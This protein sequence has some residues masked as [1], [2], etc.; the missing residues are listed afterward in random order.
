MKKFDEI[1]ARAELDKYERSNLDRLREQRQLCGEVFAGVLYHGFKISEAEERFIHACNRSMR[2][3]D[4][5]LLSVLQKINA[6][7]WAEREK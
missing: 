6:R 5:E 3:L 1:I 7:R 4:K 2:P